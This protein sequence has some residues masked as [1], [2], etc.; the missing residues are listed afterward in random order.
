M[1][2]TQ[3]RETQARARTHYKG[4]DA[5]LVC[6]EVVRQ[7]GT[8][9]PND[10]QEMANNPEAHDGAMRATH[11]QIMGDTKAA[12]VTL[13][14]AFENI[15]ETFIQVSSTEHC[16]R[17]KVPGSRQTR[18]IRKESRS[19]QQS[20]AASM[21]LDSAS[22]T[23]HGDGEILHT[24]CF[25]PTPKMTPAGLLTARPYVGT[26]GTRDAGP[27][28]SRQHNQQHI[29]AIAK[30]TTWSSAVQKK[31]GTSGLEEHGVIKTKGRDSRPNSRGGFRV[32][33]QQDTR[34]HGPT[35]LVPINTIKANAA[36]AIFGDWSNSGIF[37]TP[38]SAAFT[39]PPQLLQQEINPDSAS[40]IGDLGFEGEMQQ[41][42]ELERKERAYRQ[43]I[44]KRP[45]IQAAQAPKQLPGTESDQNIQQQPHILSNQ[46][47]QATQERP[48]TYLSKQPAQVESPLLINFG[49][50]ASDYVDMGEAQI[51]K[52]HN[53]EKTGNQ[54]LLED[55]M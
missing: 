35:R 47:I 7:T 39:M 1:A 25:T 40:T 31:E 32:D 50:G 6:P 3:A 41:A 10:W 11:R 17:V 55:L 42:I 27:G 9:R 34:T 48:R 5:R 30:A 19:E 43:T 22:S 23:G 18:D 53:D 14:R 51:A 15:K 33:Q 52:S 21:G 20:V 44:P 49:E 8:S 12:E 13:Q 37:E 28:I 36:T 46:V 26:E 45:R 4:S 29:N 54:K 2:E 38:D 16:A 24:Q